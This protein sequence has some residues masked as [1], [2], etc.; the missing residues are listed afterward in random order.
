MKAKLFS[1]EA[2]LIF[3]IILMV[4]IFSAIEPI[5]LSGGNLLDIFDQTVINGLLAIGITYAIITGGIDLSIGSIFAVVIVI[6]GDLL[7]RG[8]NPVL[9]ITVGAALGF[10]LGVVNGLLITKLKLQ[11]FIATL[12]TMSAYRGI[13]YIYTGGWPVLDIPDNFRSMLAGDVVKDVPVSVIIL[14]AFTIVSHIILKYTKLGTYIFAIGGNEEA[15]KLSGVNV[16]RTKILTYALCGVGAALAGMILLARLGSGEP[17]TGQGYELN[18]IAAAA[19]GGASL[20][21]GKG[22]MIAT[23]LGAI[24]L[25]ALKVGLVVVGVDSFWQY[26]ATG[27]IIVVAAYSEVIQDKFKK[28]RAV[29]NKNKNKNT[30][31]PKSVGM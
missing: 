22:N 20:A 24:L 19:I 15:T 29:K 25:S 31:Y 26:I 18:A 16:D 17:A 9:A 13:A 11:P 3:A 28:L 10:V 30:N 21:G 23:L 27:A 5:Y 8:M 7:V 12:G 2:S 14:I 1:R 6:T 4:I